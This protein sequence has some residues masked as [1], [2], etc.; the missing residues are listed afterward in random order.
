VQ[1]TEEALGDALGQLFIA[2]HF[3]LATRMKAFK[4]VSSVMDALKEKLQEVDWMENTTKAHA[5]LK[6]KNLKVK[7]GFPEVWKDYGNLKITRGS[8][9]ENVV[10]S[11]GFEFRLDVNR[12]NA[13]TDR[14]RWLM[15]SQTVNAYYH[16][17]LNEIVIPAAL[18][19]PPFFDPKSDIAVQYGSLGIILEFML[20][21]YDLHLI[22]YFLKHALCRC[23]SWT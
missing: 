20:Q 3:T 22:F 14:T 8:H 5:L 19:Q 11:R 10:A 15:T 13:P 18:L 17:S 23:H 1:V 12:I 16:P 2:K 21:F 9:F 6:L 7:I 4:V